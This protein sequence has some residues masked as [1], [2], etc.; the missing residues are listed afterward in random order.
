MN[1]K[2]KQKLVTALLVQH[3]HLRDDNNRLLATVWNI[4]L[5]TDGIDTKSITGHELLSLIAQGSV[6]KSG[7]ICRASRKIQ[8]QKIELRGKKWK[9][10]Q[11]HQ[12]GVV[13]QLLTMNRS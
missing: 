1:I 7:S 13:G 2:D 8:E 10:R 4:E 6:A 11:S 12:E 3:P 9:H 5:S